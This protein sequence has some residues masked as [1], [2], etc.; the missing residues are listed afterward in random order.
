LIDLKKLITKVKL[1]KYGSHNI[2]RIKKIEKL[3]NSDEYEYVYD[4]TMESNPHTFF[5]NDILVHNSCYFRI[6]EAENIKEAEKIGNK[7]VEACDKNSIP[8]IVKEIFNGDDVMRSDFEK[9][10]ISTLSYG[11]KKQY[12]F[13]TAWKDGEV[14]AKPKL[15]IT[16]LSIKRSDSPKQLSNEMKP[17]FIEIM[18][19]ISHKEIYDLMKK[20][21]ED[22]SKLSLY[23]LSAKRTANN[24]YKYTKA[25]LYEIKYKDRPYDIEK[26]FEV[27]E[28]KFKGKNIEVSDKIIEEFL[29]K[30]E[31]RYTLDGKN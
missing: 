17:F 20:I 26:L 11:K 16:G 8:M 4:V 19:G 23:D 3:E 6:L 27:L 29:R 21:E 22:Y 5:A 28:K 13:L 14:L 10:N 15:E 9:I 24:L 1:K 7:V 30:G 25:I 2:S 18:K 31:G 12:A